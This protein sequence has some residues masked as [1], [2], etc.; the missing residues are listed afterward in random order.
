M[1]RP[2]W[3]TVGFPYTIDYHFWVTSAWGCYKLPRSKTLFST[4]QSKALRVQAGFLQ[5][6][7]SPAR[8][9]VRFCPHCSWGVLLVVFP[10]PIWKHNKSNWIISPSRGENKQYVKPPVSLG[11]ALKSM[12]KNVDD[13]D[14]GKESSRNNQVR[15]WRIVPEAC[16]CVDCEKAIH[17]T[18]W[19]HPC[20]T[21][22]WKWGFVRDTT[23]KYT[24]KLW[25]YITS[26]SVVGKTSKHKDQFS[27]SSNDAACFPLCW[28]CLAHNS[29][30]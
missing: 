14:D 8:R 26:L 22:S 21:I 19:V 2:F 17:I 25:L 6:Q 27:S 5:L 11:F 30:A 1:F 4:I 18:S 9:V 3:G 16:Q 10:H 23:K 29:G 20:P 28:H 24:E 12:L 13:S 7:T 15:G